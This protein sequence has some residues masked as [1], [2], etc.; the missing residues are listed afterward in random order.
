M[1]FSS[2]V[3]TKVL[4]PNHS[5]KR[6]NKICIITPHVV[7]GL[8]SMKTI[9]AIFEK[10]SRKASCNYGIGV[11]GIIGVVDEDNRSWCSS[12]EWNDNRAIT[13]EVASENKDPYKVPDNCFDMLVDLCIDICKRHGFKRMINTTS[14]A[15][16]EKYIKSAPAN[17]VFLS[18]HNYFANK[19]CPGKY[20]GSK[21]DELCTKVNKALAEPDHKV[22]YRVQ[23]GA[24]SSKAGAEKLANT[25]KEAGY[26]VLIREEK[27]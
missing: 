11:D 7:V 5:G 21:F 1:A 13:I 27:V 25:L 19:A 20:L 14:K 24:F 3:K 16:L 6:K 26:N 2:L 12:S 8:A 18:R 23:V 17:T 22:I 9:G 10:P 4:S 15:E